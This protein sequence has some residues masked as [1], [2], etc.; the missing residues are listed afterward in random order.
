MGVAMIVEFAL[1]LIPSEKPKSL[2]LAA[3]SIGHVLSNGIEKL[4]DLIDE[5]IPQNSK[6]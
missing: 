2:I 1:R 5:A 4:S 3:A 6:K